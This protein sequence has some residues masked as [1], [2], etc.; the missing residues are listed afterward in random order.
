MPK[1]HFRAIAAIAL[2]VSFVVCTAILAR[3]V[4]LAP[5]LEKRAFLVLCASFVF[6]LLWV[7]FRRG[8][9]F[10]QLHTTTRS[11]QPI[12]FWLAFAIISALGLACVILACAI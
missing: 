2:C 3:G 10:A 7:A 12:R 6:Y 1:A 4:P 8:E 9:L 5:S 11:E